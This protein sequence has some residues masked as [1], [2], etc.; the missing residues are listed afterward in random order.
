[1]ASHWIREARFMQSPG[2]S[3]MNFWSKCVCFFLYHVLGYTKPPGGASEFENATSGSYDPATS[4]ESNGTS[5]VFSGSNKNLTETGAFSAAGGEV[6]KWALVVDASNPENSGFYRILT[7]PDANTIG[8]DFRTAASEYP[9][10]ATGL[11][12][13]ILSE[14]YQ[15]PSTNGDWWRLVTPHADAWEIECK[16]STN[17]WLEFS[18]SMDGVW[19]AS[20]EIIGPAYY[21]DNNSADANTRYLYLEGDTEGTHLNIWEFNT[22]GGSSLVT[23]AQITPW[24][25][26]PAHSTSELRAIMGP[27]TAVTVS[28]EQINREGDSTDWG[29]GKVWRD[30]DQGQHHVRC[31]EWSYSDDDEGFTVWTSREANARKSANDVMTGTHL[32]MDYLNN[33]E[34]YELLGRLEGHESIRGNLNEMQTIDHDG[35]TKNRVHLQN[36]VLLPWPGFTVQYTP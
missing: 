36:G 28:A 32:I 19:T 12:W 5:G 35:G 16:L 13:W 26:D 10:A 25:T 24:E 21:N 34:F 30:S 17:N 1:M 33:S 23:T 9:T 29:N 22:N 20:G 31:L 7:N 15:T 2:R 11:S 6:D 14:D 18:V 3:G 4:Y 8:I 27:D